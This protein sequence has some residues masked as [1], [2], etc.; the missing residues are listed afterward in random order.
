MAV[1]TISL[2][3][4][5]PRY[6]NLSTKPVVKWTL[7][8]SLRLWK[9]S[10]EWQCS[11]ANHIVGHRSVRINTLVMLTKLRSVVRGKGLTQAEAKE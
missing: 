4:T 11:D 8:N 7:Y 3:I 6:H 2:A 10:C 5:D 1:L 9:R